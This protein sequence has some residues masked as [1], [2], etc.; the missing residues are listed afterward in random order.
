MNTA[1]L[2]ISII[3]ILIALALMLRVNDY[4]NR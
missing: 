2:A 3:S 1:E 4:N